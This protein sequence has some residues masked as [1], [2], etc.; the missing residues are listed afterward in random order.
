MDEPDCFIGLGS[1]DCYS[2]HGKK[3]KKIKVKPNEVIPIY[4]GGKI[5]SCLK[6]KSKNKGKSKS[7]SKNKWVNFYVKNLDKYGSMKETSKAY[8]KIKKSLKKTKS[9]K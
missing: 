7:K 3:K 2:G 5:K 1:H 4:G 6:K 8:Q 9:K